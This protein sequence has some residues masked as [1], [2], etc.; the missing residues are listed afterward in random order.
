[1]VHAELIDS[2]TM[3]AVAYAANQMDWRASLAVAIVDDDVSQE[4]V[5]F[6]VVLIGRNRLRNL[7][8]MLNC[9]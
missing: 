8:N 9:H 5:E 2:E 4:A 3:V 1:M 6:V 7:L